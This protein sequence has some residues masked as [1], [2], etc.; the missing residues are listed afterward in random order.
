MS[1][2]VTPAELGKSLEEAFEEFKKLP[3]WNRY[4]M[5]EVFYEHFKVK[6]PQPQTVAEAC[7]FN[8]MVYM[9]FS[10]K[11]TEIRGPVEGGVR[12]IKDYLT[13]PVE[14][15]M[16]TDEA[17]VEL[18]NPKDER[19]EFDELEEMPNYEQLYAE[20]RSFLAQEDEEG[21]GSAL[22]N[23]FDEESQALIRERHR[24]WLAK[25]E[26]SKATIE[27]VR[28]AIII[29]ESSK[30]KLTAENPAPSVQPNES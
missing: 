6:K 15:K 25:E 29:K 28:R 9:H 12:E 26:D 22:F 8:P 10:E 30:Q 1:A 18:V 2:V 16:L 19:P 5:P 17:A 4:P 11:P 3:D 27:L 24:R 7:A 13:L 21:I 20:A 23:S 14:V